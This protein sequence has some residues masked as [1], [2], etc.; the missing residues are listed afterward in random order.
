MSSILLPPC[1]AVAGCLI[2]N[3]IKFI[4]TKRLDKR[5]FVA[6]LMLSLYIGLL[7]AALITYGLQITTGA[8]GAVRIW[9]IKERRLLNLVPFKTI[10]A[11]LSSHSIRDLG[12]LAVN[13]VIMMPFALLI[14]NLSPK[15]KNITC[16]IIIAAFTAGIE[17]VQYFIGRSCDIDDLLLNVG[18]AAIALIIYNKIKKSKFKKPQSGTP[19]AVFPYKEQDPREL[20]HGSCP[21]GVNGIWKTIYLKSPFLTYSSLRTSVTV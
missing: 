20:T 14:K 2:V 5:Q 6:Q 19:T 15:T 13:A 12:N 18:G 1:L 4:I 16:I 9:G 21:L 10:F 11:Q 7:I 3:A 17:A 8:G